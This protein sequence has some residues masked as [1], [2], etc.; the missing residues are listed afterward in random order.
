MPSPDP[1]RVRRRRPLLWVAV[2]VG[3]GRKVTGVRAVK[4]GWCPAC[5]SEILPYRDVIVHEPWGW[6]HVRCAEQVKSGRVLPDD[7]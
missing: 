2:D 3:N 1:D 7:G 4:H 6:V 5:A